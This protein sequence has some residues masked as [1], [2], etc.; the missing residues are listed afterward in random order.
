LGFPSSWPAIARCFWLE[1]MEAYALI[2]DNGVRHWVRHLFILTGHQS[3]DYTH[4][5]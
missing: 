1:H 4:N 3:P 5:L 2:F